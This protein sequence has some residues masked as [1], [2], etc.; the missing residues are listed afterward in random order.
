MYLKKAVENSGVFF[1]NKISKK[2]DKKE[3]LKDI[4]AS[5][6]AIYNETEDKEVKKE[7]SNL[8]TNIQNYQL[9]SNLID[10]IYTYLPL[11][12]D[13]LDN[14][15]FIMKKGEKKNQYL[16]K[17]VLDFKDI[18]KVD[19]TL[20]LFE[21]DLK[22][23]LDVENRDFEKNLKKGIEVLKSVLKKEGFENIFIS[24]G[25]GVDIKNLQKF[26]SIID[27]KA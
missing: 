10:G 22:I 18:G 6:L 3:I 14:S 8:V 12:W 24:F 13:G 1:E 17:I 26:S 16:C 7:I 15:E 25:K 2:V 21:N 23:V 4:K 19:S 5:L 20:F 11:I 27:I 9:L